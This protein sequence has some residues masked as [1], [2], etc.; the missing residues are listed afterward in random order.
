MTVF[1]SLVFAHCSPSK[2]T[3]SDHKKAQPPGCAFT[4]KLSLLTQ[5][6]KEPQRIFAITNQQVFGL[7]VV[8]Q[9]QFVG[10]AAY[11]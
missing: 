8:V 2:M 10:F 3:S 1:D 6:L 5:G 11:A 9:G 7:L 4:L